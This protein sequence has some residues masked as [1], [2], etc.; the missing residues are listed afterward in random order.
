MVAMQSVHTHGCIDES[1]FSL[2]TRAL[3]LSVSENWASVHSGRILGG[4]MGYPGGPYSVIPWAGWLALQHIHAGMV[5][6]H[7][8]SGRVAAAWHGDGTHG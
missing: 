4:G 7:V 3:H 6:L 8:P 1:I 5:G 2:G